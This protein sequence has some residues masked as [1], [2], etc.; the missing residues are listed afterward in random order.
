MRGSEEEWRRGAEE[1]MNRDLLLFT[2]VLSDCTC[3]LLVF[4][5]FLSGTA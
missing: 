4:T 1:E 3:V 5:W 2:R